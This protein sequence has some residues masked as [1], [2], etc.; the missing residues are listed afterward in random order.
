MSERAAVALVA[1]LCVLS[2]AAVG[3]V[4]AQTSDWTAGKSGETLTFE[5]GDGNTISDTVTVTNNDVNNSVDIS[6][7]IGGGHSATGP[8]TVGPGQSATVDVTLNAG[9]SESAT[10]EIG[11]GG[12]TETVDYTVRTPAYVE[13]SNVPDW[14]DDEGALRGESRDAQVTV[15][16][17]GGYSGFNGLDVSGADGIS[18]LESAS[19][20]AGGS[21]QVTVTFTADDRAAQYSDIGGMFSVDPD[22]GYNVDSSVTLESFV[23]LP[24]QFGDVSLGVGFIQ[25]DEP[26]S[27]GTITRTAT[28]DVENTGD[29]ELDFGGVDVDSTDFQE[30]NVVDTPGTIAPDSSEPVEI[31]I[32]ASTDM[33]EGSYDFDATVQSSD[34]S[35]D[36]ADVSETIEVRHGISMDVSPTQTGVGDVPIGN[37]ESTS[38]TVSEELGYRNIR[39]PEVTLEDGNEEYIEVTSGVGSTI[40]SG[41]SATVGYEVQFDPSADIGSGYTWTFVIDGEGVDSREVTVTATPIP[42]NLDP[43]LEDLDE[44]PAGSEALDQT[45]G[46]TVQLVNEMDQRIREDDVPRED[47]TT[48]LTFGDGV[49]RYLEAIAATDELIENGSY[50]AAQEELIRAAVAYDTMTTYGQAIRDDDLRSQAMTIRDTA[51][52]ELESRLQTQESYYQEQLEAED[53]AP[54][55]EASIQ[56]ELALIASLR[57]D[58]ERAQSLEADSEAAFET[59]STLV[60]EGE[61]E[62]QQAVNTWGGMQSDIFVSVPGQPLILNPTHYG[63]FEE[64][65]E[66]LLSN[67]DDAEAAFTEAGETTRAETVAEERSQRASALTIARW[68]LFASMGL[69]VVFVVALI[70]HTSRGMYWYVQDSKESV[71]GDFLV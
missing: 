49:I 9:G 37:S 8:G 59:Y 41:S 44:A 54:I 42:L 52:S 12:N 33:G 29:R 3:G 45:S 27:A 46:Q 38:V 4:T 63:E 16:E 10:L 51:G 17:V 69:T 67:Y 15:E 48:V 62:R 35:V 30:V 24:A 28:I 58:T 7:S 61:T 56:S 19:A 55:E 66:T 31:E 25:F 23:A 5:P 64:R 18:G 1:A 34:A 71:T 47:V 39:N 20:S 2:M 53:T 65:S 26:R 32:V 60:S 43:L 6:A 13:I 40:G 50:D 11:G 22:D 36:S 57:G 21:D 68:S 14:V 70:V